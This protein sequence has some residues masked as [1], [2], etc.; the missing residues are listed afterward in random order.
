MCLASPAPV[1]SVVNES[2]LHFPNLLNPL[3]P[4]LYQFIQLWMS[5]ASNAPIHSDVN[6]P[7]WYPLPQFIQLSLASTATIHSAVNESGIHGPSSL[8]CE[9]VWPPLSRFTQ[10]WMSLASTVQFHSAVKEPPILASTSQFIQLQ[11]SSKKEYNYLT[12]QQNICMH[13]TLHPVFLG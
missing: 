6:Y 1:H 2:G 8:S 13:R 11:G 12:M 9:W 7:L 3:R 10:L 5:L 4:P